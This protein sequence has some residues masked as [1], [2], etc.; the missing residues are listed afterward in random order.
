VLGEAG[1]D[2]QLLLAIGQLWGD[3][4]FERVRFIEASDPEDPSRLASL[5]GFR[6]RRAPEGSE[7]T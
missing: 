1:S 5:F 4:A 3:Q 2:L 6:A 7:V